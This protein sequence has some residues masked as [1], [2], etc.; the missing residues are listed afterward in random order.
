MKRED[1]LAVYEAGP[2]AV[3]QLVTGLVQEFTTLIQQ[4]REEIAELKERVRTL[5]QQ[6]NK[7]SRNSSKPPSTDG[8]NKP[9]PKSLRHK[10][11]NAVGGQQGHPGHTLK[12]TAKPDHIVVH[13]LSSCS[14]G[15]CLEEQ[16]PIRYEKRQVWDIP[17]IH[18][19]VTEHRAEVKQCP[20]CGGIAKAVFPP[21]AATPAQYGPGMRAFW[22]YLNQYQLMPYERIAELFKDWFGHL[23][24]QATIVN[25]NLD[26]YRRLEPVEEQIAQT[27]LQ[28]P[29]VHFDET[30]LQ[31]KGRKH[32]L[33]VAGTA[34]HTHFTIHAHRGQKG[35]E[36]AGILPNYEGVAIHDAWKPYWAYD[37]C[38]H[39]L[40]N[41]HHLR[42][43]TYI[44]EQEKQLWAGR[45]IELLVDMKHA[46]DDRYKRAQSFTPAELAG[47]V[48]RYDLILAH[49]LLEERMKSTAI[50]QKRKGRLKQSKAKNLLDRLGS[51]R[52]EVLS[53]LCEFHIPFDNNQ[54]ER[55]VRMMKVQQKVSGTFRSEQGAKTFCRIR[56]FLS[57]LKKH[58]LPVLDSIQTV[59]KGNVVLPI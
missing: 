8:F 20:A 25:S 49:G 33:H 59:L 26:L 10:G 57:T 36:G 22:I 37:Q 24:S 46:V 55:D 9:Q 27:I 7:N 32:W 4:Q 51:R 41:A 12:F 48:E 6:V 5:E 40:C 54:A 11:K 50:E 42:E 31:V 43:L 56:G 47:F 17:P 1:I 23:P 2:D 19:E 34:S 29:V 45:M 18:V 14:C 30:G 3:V 44:L 53:F 15:R 28:A 52:L 13:S 16:T 39:A 58:S 38:Q 35:L 21:E